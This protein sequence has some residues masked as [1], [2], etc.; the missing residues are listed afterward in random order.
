VNGLS[1][2]AD[3]PSLG[4]IRLMFPIQVSRLPVQN[5]TG[6]TIRVPGLVP[7]IPDIGM[8]RTTIRVTSFYGETFM[9]GTYG[10]K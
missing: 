3:F 9:D 1:G 7:P 10:S 8:D 2:L 6:T 5:L 4:F